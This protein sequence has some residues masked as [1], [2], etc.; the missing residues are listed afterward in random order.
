MP[1]HHEHP[2]SFDHLIHIVDDLEAAM[3]SYDNLGLP[4]HAALSMPGF[5]NAAWGIDDAR[6]I[7]LAVIDDWDAASGSIYGE[8]L[9]VMRPTI[10]AST[11]PGLASF[12]VHVPDAPA[13]AALF[14]DAGYQVTVCDIRFD[15]QVD[16][17]DA[18]FTEVFVTDAPAWFPFFISYSPPREVIAQLRTDH[19]VTQ[20][21]D[22][23]PPS[24]RGPDLVSLLAYSHT[25]SHDA[26]V[27][28]ELLRCELRGTTVALPGAQ[29][30]FEHSPSPDTTPGLYG[31]SV[32]RAGLTESPAFVAGAMATSAITQE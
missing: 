14:R 17:Q 19:R 12:A 21:G 32:R 13:T 29:V 28:S 16:G 20:G 6:Y 30:H 31:F 2:Y 23:E 1:G 4:T 5:R 22:S 8:T 24:E 7:E 10:E 27:L 18:G 25:P 26:R 9:S 15:D 11:T 3:T